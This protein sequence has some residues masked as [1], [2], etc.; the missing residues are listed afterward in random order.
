MLRGS[1][2]TQKP[3]VGSVVNWGH[4]LA[5]GL[6]GCW[7]FNEGAGGYAKNLARVVSGGTLTN[8]NYTGISGWG[9]GDR[10]PTLFFDGTNDTITVN[11]AP[12]LQPATPTY[13]A[14]FRTS[15]ASSQ[16]LICSGTGG[17]RLYIGVIGAGGTEATSKLSFL[18][19]DGSAFK[20]VTSPGTVNDGIWHTAIGTFDGSILRLY[21]DGIQVN[22]LSA[23][24]SATY[25]A[26]NLQIGSDQSGVDFPF[27]GPIDYSAIY[28]RPLTPSETLRI[29]QNL[30]AMIQ[31]PAATK[32]YSYAA[33]IATGNRRRRILCVGRMM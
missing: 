30:Y 21:L 19:Y 4:P 10:G 13:I 8:F 29:Y 18:I 16:G 3:P 12:A 2:G 24:G 22:T 9:A 6:V 15:S 32:F 5:Q 26:N 27:G 7:L 31:P 17:T 20:V 28:R 23:S 33:S 14:R 1:W 11:V 25:L